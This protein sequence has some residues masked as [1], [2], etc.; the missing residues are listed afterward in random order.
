[1]AESSNIHSEAEKT[2]L[3]NDPPATTFEGIGSP[4][5]RARLVELMREEVEFKEEAIVRFG[6][7]RIQIDTDY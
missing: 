3:A 6:Q 4:R 7:H 1:M 5:R 2:A